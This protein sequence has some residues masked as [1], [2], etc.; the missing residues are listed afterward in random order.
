MS[1]LDMLPRDRSV[2][3]AK[4]IDQL[5]NADVQI[6]VSFV[7]GMTEVQALEKPDW[8]KTCSDL[9]DHFTLTILDKYRNADGIS[10]IFDRFVTPV[11]T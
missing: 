4:P 5:A 8:I 3:Q 11:D 9:T 1:I 7:D 2:E 10:L 6:K